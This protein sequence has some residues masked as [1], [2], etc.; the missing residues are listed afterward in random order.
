MQLPLDK[1]SI[2]NLAKTLNWRDRTILIVGKGPSLM[3]ADEAKG[4]SRFSITINHSCEVFRG[5]IAYFTDLQALLDCESTLM[6]SDQYVV[7]PL[8][9]HIHGTPTNWTIFDLANH[10][11]LVEKLLV[12]NRIYV[13]AGSNSANQWRLPE[14]ELRY[15]SAEPAYQ[16]A[17]LLGAQEVLT[18]GIDGGSQY[19]SCISDVG[20]S[21]LLDNGRATYDKQFTQLVKLQSRFGIRLRSFDFGFQ[22]GIHLPDQSRMPGV[23]TSMPPI[24][25]PTIASWR[26]TIFKLRAAARN[27]V[28]RIRQ[29]CSSEFLKTRV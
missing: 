15:F 3:F 19:A 21:R 4:L 14:I 22:T 25:Y 23:E 10:F 2:E 5:E 20:R 26:I 28:W 1:Y 8:F 17:V 24:N 12:E 16:L 11:Q 27:Q 6:S 18:L 13:F 7:T 9:P 29:R